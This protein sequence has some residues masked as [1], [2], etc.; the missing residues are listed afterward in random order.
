MEDASKRASTQQVLI[1]A[2]AAKD[3]ACTQMAGPASVRSFPQD[4]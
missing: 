4:S 3:S 2:N 1:T